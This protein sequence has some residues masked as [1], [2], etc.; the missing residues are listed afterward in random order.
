MY[1]ADDSLG[2]FVG[3]G[4]ILPLVHKSAALMLMSTSL[5]HNNSLFCFTS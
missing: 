5:C 2:S 3:G 4:C 1:K